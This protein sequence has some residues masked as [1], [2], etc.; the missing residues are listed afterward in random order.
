MTIHTLPMC[1]VLNDPCYMETEVEAFTLTVDL[2]K[3]T[4]EILSPDLIPIRLVAPGT[5][6]KQPASRVLKALC[7][8]GGTVTLIHERA[9]PKG[10]MPFVGSDKIFITLAGAFT[11]YKLCIYV[12]SYSQ[13]L[14][15]QRKLMDMHAMY[16]LAIMT[17]HDITLGRDFLR[18]CDLQVD[19]RRNVMIYMDV[20]VTMR[21]RNYF[22]DPWRL[23]EALSA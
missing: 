10:A 20:E 23:N 9:L 14:V 4:N 12:I 7:D 13:N 5:I 6:Q 2:P 15:A 18:K 22:D 11:S 21:P 3:G 1:Y 17:M 8:S 16:L 19:F